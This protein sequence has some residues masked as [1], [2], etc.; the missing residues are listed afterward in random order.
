MAAPHREAFA[1][2]RRSTQSELMDEPG[3]AETDVLLALREIR[4]INRSLGGISTTLAGLAPR[5]RGRRSPVRLLDVGT[6]GADLPVA[7]ARWCRR[8]GVA[9]RIVAVDRGG[10][11]CRFAAAAVADYPEIEVCRADVRSLPFA[12]RSFH[13]AHCA[14]FLHHFDQDEVVGVLRRLAEVTSEGVVVNDLHRHPLAHA[15]IRLLT[16]LFSQSALVQNDAP[17]SVRRGFRAADL[18]DIRA[19]GG[20]SSFHYRWRWAFRYLCDVGVVGGGR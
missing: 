20:F 14:M 8:N 12:P 2:G 1:L 15:A 13:L 4:I 3:V 5:L 10:S 19:R 7:I 17:L 16:R 11:A 6:G 9:V 18:E